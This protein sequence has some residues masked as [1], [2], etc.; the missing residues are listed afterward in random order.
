MRKAKFENID[1]PVMIDTAM[2][3]SYLSCGRPT[4]VKIG[5]TANAKIICGKR[6]F[7][8]VEKIHKY[9]NDISA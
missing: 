4:A 9:L 2:L 6:V 8:N 5:E 3:Q 7:W 1:N